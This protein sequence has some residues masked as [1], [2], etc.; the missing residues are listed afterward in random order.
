MESVE[1]EDSR[2]RRREQVRRAQRTHRDRKA[3]Y[4]RSLEAEV[5]TLRTQEAAHDAECQMYRQVIRRLRE[6]IKYHNIPLPPDLASSPHV[7]SPQATVEL[8]TLSD[9]SQTIRAQLPAP[10]YVCPLPSDISGAPPLYSESSFS[11]SEILPGTSIGDAPDQEPTPMAHAHGLWTAQTGVDFVLG[12]EQVCLEHHAVHSVDVEGT[13]HEMM[14]MSPIMS[15]SP[16]LQQ[17]TEPGSGLPDGAKWSVPAV[18]LERLLEFADR[19]R[20]DGEITPVEAWQS[21]RQHPNFPN[22]TRDGL[23]SMKAMLFP[24]VECYG[25][26]AVIDRAYFDAVMLQVMGPFR[27]SR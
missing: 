1:E 10:G 25:F 23:A 7:S 17:T 9:R 20:L 13:G 11:T 26:G 21:I 16:P 12:L 4:V 6:L 5:A 24:E 2:A 3:T 8:V 15:R 27:P 18:E 19:L 14:L 22:L